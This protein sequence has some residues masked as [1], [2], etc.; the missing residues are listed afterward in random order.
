[1]E[2]YITHE[3]RNNS[4]ERLLKEKILVRNK[5]NMNWINSFFFIWICRQL[6]L[7]E[8]ISNFTGFPYLVRTGSAAFRLFIANGVFVKN[9]F[10]SLD[11][12]F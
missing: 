6:N 5:K 1:M 11:D 10:L 7:G 9:I 12:K 4:I 3:K 8:L 2:L